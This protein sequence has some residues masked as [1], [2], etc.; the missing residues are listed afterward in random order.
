[1]IIGNKDI[2]N[3]VHLID[4]VRGFAII[5]MVVYHTF[6][7]LVEIFNMNI[8][9]YYSSFVDNLVTLFAGLFI[10]ISG[11]ACLY[12]RN[13]LKRGFICFM[14]GMIIT[15][16]TLIFMKDNL[17]LFG[18]LHMLGVNMMLFSVLSPIV[19]K[20]PPSIGIICCMVLCIF[21]YNF[22]I[23]YLGF[24]NF[25]KID[26]PN[27]LYS[28]NILFPLGLSKPTFFSVDYFPLIPWSFC[29]FSGS[30]FGVLLKN[31]RM[32]KY[33]YKMHIR[34]LAFVGR[35]T[36]IIYILHQPIVL[37]VLYIIFWIIG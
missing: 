30:F 25:L 23:G 11:A 19:K 26:L 2:T 22:Q 20:V 8:P 35:N 1:M 31:N 9:I 21:T 3:R 27:Q 32:P 13:N 24:E 37:L 12:S 5:C 33:F 7:D 4:E 16:F 18:I 6:Y 34:P 14:L 17:D 10:F 29:F 15:A 28:T 36:L